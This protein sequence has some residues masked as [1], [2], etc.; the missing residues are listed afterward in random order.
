[1]PDKLY[2]INQMAGPL[3]Y[4]KVRF[5]AGAMKKKAVIITGHSDT[6]KKKNG[7]IEIVAAP[8]YRRNGNISRIASWV[9]Y[10]LFC[11]RYVIK[12][13]NSAFF[14]ISSNPPIFSIAFYWINK[15]K[16]QK[17]SM[18]IY[19]IYPDVLANSGIFSNSSVINKYWSVL[20]RRLF[21]QAENVITLSQSMADLL[22]RKYSAQNIDR[23]KVIP[24]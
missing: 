12:I 16:Q 8:E 23:V 21:N 1:M 11:I 22:I 18:I 5:I 13:R 15:I 19:D 24:L 9:N 6:I 4:D 14:L 2:A 3:F 10:T 20:N 17:Y 7:D